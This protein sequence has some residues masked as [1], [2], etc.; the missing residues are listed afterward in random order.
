MYC[1][2]RQ[3]QRRFCATDTAGVQPIGRRLSP[4]PRD[5]DLAAKQ[6]HTDHVCRLMVST[7]VI[8]GITWITIQST[9][10]PTP[11]GWKAELTW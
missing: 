4:R 1:H 10:L 7:P 9:H 3:L 5:F 2:K 11:K 6:P 8:H